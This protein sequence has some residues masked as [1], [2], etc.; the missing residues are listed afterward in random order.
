MF[1]GIEADPIPCTR[2]PPVSP[3]VVKA[4]CERSV[5]EKRLT[6]LCQCRVR[7]WQSRFCAKAEHWNTDYTEKNR[8]HGVTVASPRRY[9]EASLGMTEG[10]SA[11]TPDPRNP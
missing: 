6:L 1:R 7:A 4:A 2:R 11:V 3:C 10:S 8:L 5:M 9:P